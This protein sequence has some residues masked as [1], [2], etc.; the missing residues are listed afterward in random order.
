MN[1]LVREIEEDIRQERIDKLWHSFGKVM[2]SVSVGIVLVTIAIVV[3][4]DQK[5]SRAAG[6]TAQFIK[7]MDQLNIE[8]FKGAIP[9][10]ELLAQDEKSP[11]YA[12]AMLRKAQAEESLGNAADAQKTYGQLA[13]HDTTM[14][15]LAMLLGHGSSASGD[16]VAP[17]EKGA[18]F[19][20]TQSEFRAW[21][22]FQQGKKD[23]AVDQFVA[24][25]DDRATPAPMHDRVGE[26]LQY[27]A[28]EKLGMRDEKMSD[29]RKEK[30]K[31]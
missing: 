20:Y 2:V 16:I 15:A 22:L 17:A 31:L 1:E 12:L 19:Y 28:P 24:L 23:Q 25:Y 18:A 27:I 7:G 9:I 14:S 4:Q 6:K 26:V 10:F 8:D 30:E 5:R 3:V 13:S 29:E 21:Q 11:Y